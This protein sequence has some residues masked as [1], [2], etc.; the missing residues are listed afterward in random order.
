MQLHTITALD[1]EGHIIAGAGTVGDRHA[2]TMMMVMTDIGTLRDNRRVHSKP[3][4]MVVFVP[5]AYPLEKHYEKGAKNQEKYKEKHNFKAAAEKEPH[6]ICLL[7]PGR[8][9]LKA[10]IWFYYSRKA[11]RGQGVLLRKR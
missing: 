10:G 7:S 8:C 6:V 3:R 1:L 2:G 9:R 5:L 11:R 4:G